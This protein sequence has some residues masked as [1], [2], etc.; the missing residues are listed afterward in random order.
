MEYYVPLFS[1]IVDS[2]L[3]CEPD[4]VVKVFLT[5]LAKKDRDGVVRGTAFNIAQWAK[6]TEA[7]VLESLKVLSSPDTKRL[8][9]Q[10]NDGRRIERV[11]DGWLILNA[12]YY[13]KLMQKANRQQYQRNWQANNRRNRPAEGTAQKT[14]RKRPTAS[15]TIAQS[16]AE[17]EGRKKR[18][19]D[20]LDRGDQ[21]AADAIAAEDLPGSNN[22]APT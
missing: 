13:Q 22:G 5:M 3:W 9:P 1:K 18:Y 12:E 19:C 14:K 17:D 21:A 7:E 10:P 6:K 20:A 2:S 11:E 4:F 8:E 16:R 15:K